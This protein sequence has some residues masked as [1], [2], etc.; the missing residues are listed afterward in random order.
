MV[1]ADDVRRDLIKVRHIVDAAG[2]LL[3]QVG[4]Y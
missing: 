1:T 2:L 3:D 4:S